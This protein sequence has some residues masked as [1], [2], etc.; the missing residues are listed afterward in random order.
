[1]SNVLHLFAIDG[2]NCNQKGAD[3]N[4]LSYC[5]KMVQLLAM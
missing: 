5:K 2:L 1:M 3:K 4:Q